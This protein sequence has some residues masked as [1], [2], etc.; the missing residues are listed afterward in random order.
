MVKMCIILPIFF[1][2]DFSDLFNEFQE[3]SRV[4]KVIS[5]ETRRRSHEG[6]HKLNGDGAIDNATSLTSGLRR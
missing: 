2:R 3:Q 4:D 1:V 5:Y 6:L